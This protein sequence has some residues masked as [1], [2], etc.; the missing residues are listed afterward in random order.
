MKHYIHAWNEFYNAIRDPSWPN[1]STEHEFHN[2]PDHIKK[3]I[4]EV[5]NGAQHVA[6]TASGLAP[7]LENI[8]LKDNKSDEHV[9]ECK[10]QLAVA[11]D[12]DVYYD[13][14]MD[15]GGT[16]FGQNFPKIIKHLYSNRVFE[17]C[18][19][20]CS[21]PS[22]IGFR[23]LADGICNNLT[24]MDTYKP[25]LLA[26]EKTIKHMPDRFAGAVSIF[27]NDNVS[28]LSGVYDL[29]VSDPP[30]YASLQFDDPNTNRLGVDYEWKIHENFFRNIK[31]NL[32]PDGV[33]LL[34]EDRMGSAPI[35][36]DRFIEESNLQITNA[37][38][39]KA[40]P[41]FWYLE[42]RHK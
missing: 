5:H 27:H 2:L 31:K 22:F 24:L 6:L 37:F 39:E 12:F 11:N 25:S 42:V 34:Q 26:A 41:E 10:L 29:I 28:N 32:A 30:W 18:L 19:E 38:Y 40:F 13:E 14:Y 7:I 23:L 1:C 15:G 20:W 16:T 9:P 21:G 8:V 3:E 35:C 4:L 33:I 36:F 17:N